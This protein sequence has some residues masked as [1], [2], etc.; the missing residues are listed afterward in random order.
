MPGAHFRFRLSSDLVASKKLE[1][2]EF[3]RLYLSYIDFAAYLSWKSL[4]FLIIIYCYHFTVN[5]DF[6]TV[7]GVS[8]SRAI[9]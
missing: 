8:L 9:H 1:S 2:G 3:V 5:K 7:N 6:Q 4:L